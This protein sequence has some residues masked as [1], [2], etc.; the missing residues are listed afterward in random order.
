MPECGVAP[1]GRRHGFRSAPLRHL[2]V[3]SCQIGD[4][5]V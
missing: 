3:L 2:L 4:A 5:A 1:G